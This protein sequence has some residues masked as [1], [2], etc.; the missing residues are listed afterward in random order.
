MSPRLASLLTRLQPAGVILFARNITG[1]EQTYK[2]LKDCQ[3]CV[4][5]PLFTCVDM[6]G[7]RVDRFR[8]VIGSSSF[9]RRCLCHRQPQALPQARQSDRR[10]LPDVGI[11]YRLRAGRRSRIRSLEDGDEFARGFGRSESR[12]SSMPA[13]FWQ[14]CASANVVGSAKHFPGLGEANLDT[15]HELPVRQQ[16]VEEA[17][18]GRHVSLP[19]H[20]P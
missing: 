5:T 8:N 2:L 18:G 6:E 10:I 9:R 17:L 1:G 19:D 14:D 13:N 7:G 11:Q 12:R 3:A 16:V 20:A 4:S 15:H